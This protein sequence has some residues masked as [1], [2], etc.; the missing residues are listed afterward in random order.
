[1]KFVR[2]SSLA[3]FA[4]VTIVVLLGAWT[5][6]GRT[7]TRPRTPIKRVHQ[8]M[9]ERNQL[10]V[11]RQDPVVFE[12]TYEVDVFYDTPK[13]YSNG[14][15]LTDVVLE[16]QVD[17]QITDQTPWTY[18]SNRTVLKLP[19][20][21]LADPHLPDELIYMVL[22]TF[23]RGLYDRMHDSMV[24]LLTLGALRTLRHVEI[25]SG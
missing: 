2:R 15:L 1:M 5:A 19:N 22:D 21:L 11:D 24:D 6:A 25:P 7:A 17:V 4:L 10:T 3:V 13:E 9:Q 8:K 16:A 18:R 14:I 20:D 12:A 23:S